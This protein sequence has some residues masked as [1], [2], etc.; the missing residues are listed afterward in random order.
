MV[1]LVMVCVGRRARSLW[2]EF[3]GPMGLNKN[4]PLNASRSIPSPINSSNGFVWDAFLSG[5]ERRARVSHLARSGGQIRVC[6]N[7]MSSSI[8]PSVSVSYIASF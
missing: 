4:H 3:R 7:H 6:P 5:G 8:L 1:S 2:E